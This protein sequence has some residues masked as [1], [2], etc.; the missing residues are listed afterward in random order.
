MKHKRTEEENLKPVINISNKRIYA[1][2]WY[3]G[4]GEIVIFDKHGRE[5]FY[6]DDAKLK[7]HIKDLKSTIASYELALQTLEAAKN[8]LDD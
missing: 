6:R 4:S 2:Y 5:V 3:D 1:S 8:K 7:N